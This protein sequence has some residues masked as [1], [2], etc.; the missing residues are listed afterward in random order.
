[1]RW[2][3]FRL[4]IFMCAI[5]IQMFAIK[6]AIASGSCNYHQGALCYNPGNYFEDCS[7]DCDSYDCDSCGLIGPPQ[8]ECFTIDC[9]NSPITGS[10][11]WDNIGSAATVDCFNGNYIPSRMDCQCSGLIDCNYI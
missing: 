1:M 4:R 2:F 7:C 9:T 10:A 5:A 3:G 11:C 6:L 8:Y